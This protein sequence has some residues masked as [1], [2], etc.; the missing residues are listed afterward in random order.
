M[1]A[2]TDPFA[3][4][5]IPC[6]DLIDWVEVEFSLPCEDPWLREAGT[7][8]HAYLEAAAR[9]WHENP[10]WM[11]FLDLDSP[12]YDLK[13]AERDLYLSEWR[14][15]LG[16]RRVLD[17]GC[18]I[19]R[20]TQTFLDR[21]ATVVGVDGDLESLRRCAWHAAGRSGA[22]ELHWSS[23]R[24]LPEAADF[25]VIVACEVLCYV[26]EAEEVLAELTRRLRPGGALL[27]SWE[28]PWGWATAEDAPAGG[29]DA[30]LRGA[31]EISLPGDRWVRTVDRDELGAMLDRAGLEV[32]AI[33]A[34]HYVP[35]G[36]LERC[37]DE[38][39]D[40]ERLLAIEAACRVHPVW[41]P[42]NRIWT[43]TAVRPG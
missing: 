15:W 29:L 3:A 26:P 33:Q 21:G 27:L 11:D 39:L 19:G 20:L 23:A 31:G 17:V 10:E 13:R 1:P 38:D 24:R 12:A 37:L 43:A 5:P 40:L 35:D 41:A 7:E 28:A 9:A 2:N 16:A 22:L 18:G 8:G 4:G 32:R 42:L 25:E 6:A 34:T 36:P 14:A 30:A